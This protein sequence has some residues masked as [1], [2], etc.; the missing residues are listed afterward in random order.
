MPLLVTFNKRPIKRRRRVPAGLLL[1]FFSPNRGWRG[2]QLLI[3]DDEWIE[4]GR[5]ESLPYDQFP[6]I[7][8]LA[9]EFATATSR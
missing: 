8:A 1:T 4:Y 5:V 3:S 7:R 2:D 6:D 9:R